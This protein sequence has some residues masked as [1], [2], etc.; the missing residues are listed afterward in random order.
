MKLF[1]DESVPKLIKDSLF[2]ARVAIVDV[3]GLG[4]SGYDDE[5]VFEEA[6][7]QERTFVT[8]NLKFVTK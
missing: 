2:K 7:R 4:L 3:L 5:A 8:V 1:L 6:Q